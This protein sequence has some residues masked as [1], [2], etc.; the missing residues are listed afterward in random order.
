LAKRLL[1]NVFCKHCKTFFIAGSTPGGRR[2]FVLKNSVSVVFFFVLKSAWVALRARRSESGR[3]GELGASALHLY[4][5]RGVPKQVEIP[6]VTAL[7][8]RALA[9]W[10]FRFGTALFRHTLR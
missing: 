2:R 9:G 10:P 1:Q 3:K 7:S 6:Q 4:M 5:I 8:H